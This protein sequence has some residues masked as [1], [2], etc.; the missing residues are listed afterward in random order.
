[1]GRGGRK[2]SQ[3]VH[4]DPR[5]AFSGKATTAPKRKNFSGGFYS[6]NY[7]PDTNIYTDDYDY[8]LIKVHSEEKCVGLNCSI[9][10]PSDHK[11]IGL[12]M[13]WSWGKKQIM[14]VCE[15]DN[16][17]PDPDDKAHRES[18]GETSDHV[19]PCGCCNS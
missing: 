16:K 18:L 9:H 15:H 4:I 8:E 11:M 10:N 1:M 13:K 2:S 12:P 3:Q 6:K 7:D 17:H 19:C 14:R 5:E